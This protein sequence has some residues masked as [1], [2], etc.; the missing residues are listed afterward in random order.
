MLVDIKLNT[1]K[2]IQV[3]P[4]EAES[5]IQQGLA[6]SD[7]TSEEKAV[8]APKNKAVKAKKNK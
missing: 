7:L 1:G 6:T 4:H 2:T 5:L 8:E 3:F